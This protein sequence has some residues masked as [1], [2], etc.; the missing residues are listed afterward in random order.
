V[1]YSMAGSLRSSSMRGSTVLSSRKCLSTVMPR[2]VMAYTVRFLPMVR[3]STSCCWIRKSKYC[4]STEQFTFALYIICVSFN[5]PLWLRT[6][7]ISTY[8]SSLDLRIFIFHTSFLRVCFF[9]RFR[10]KY[11]TDYSY[12]FLFF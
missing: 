9:V 7:S 2:C 11:F 4:F 12:A 1:G 10:Y 8:I 3:S 6:L 5:G